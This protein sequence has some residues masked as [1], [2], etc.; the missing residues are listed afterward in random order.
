MALA[1]SAPAW[2]QMG[3]D[4]AAASAERQTGGRALAVERVDSSRG[5]M[6]RVKVVTPRGEVHVVLIEA[7]DGAGT[8][9]EGR[10]NDA[11]GA[12]PGFRSNPQGGRDG[13]R[14]HRPAR[15]D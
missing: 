1:L 10:R 8:R 3:R 9:S 4:Q 15:G 7:D 12:E 14:N 13:R 2:A 11:P 5:P 6:W